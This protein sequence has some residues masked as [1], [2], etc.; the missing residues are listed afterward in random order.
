MP[1]NEG[2]LRL[3]DFEGWKEIKYPLIKFSN[4]L[5][6]SIFDV[7]SSDIDDKLPFVL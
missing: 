2:D 6:F 4:S 7:I 3:N 5:K 1:W